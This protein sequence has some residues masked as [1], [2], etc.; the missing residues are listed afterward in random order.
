MLRSKKAWGYNSTPQ[1]AFMQKKVPIFVILSES[2]KIFP[3]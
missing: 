1:Y 2:C 3:K